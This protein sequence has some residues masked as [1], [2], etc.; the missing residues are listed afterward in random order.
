MIEKNTLTPPTEMCL[1]NCTC[2]Q[3]QVPTRWYTLHVQRNCPGVKLL[4]EYTATVQ[5]VQ[6][7]SQS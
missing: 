2:A 6:V 7:K 5:V 4:H 1:C 3:Y